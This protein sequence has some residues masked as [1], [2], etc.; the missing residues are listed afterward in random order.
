MPKTRI[1][2]VEWAELEGRRPRPAGC[3]GW[4]CTGKACASHWRA[5]PRTTAQADFGFCATEEQILDVLGQPLDA[6]FGAQYGATPAG[7][8][9]DFPL[10]DLMAKAR[11]PA[12]LSPGRDDGRQACASAGRCAYP[13][14]TRRSIWTICTWRATRPPNCWRR[15]RSTPGLACGHRLLRSRRGGAPAMPVEEDA[16]ATPRAQCAPL[17]VRA[18]L[19]IDANGNTPSTWRSACWRRRR[20]AAS[21]GWRS[22]FTRTMHFMKTCRRGCGRRGCPP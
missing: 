19:M 7:Q 6:L 5:L 21:T 2:A 16:A 10:W 12:G 22:R 11:K 4:A 17:R 9:F 15:R 1:S 3:N 20:T 8:F 14:T 18:I 13:A